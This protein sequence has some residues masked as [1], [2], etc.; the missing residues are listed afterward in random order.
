MSG[1]CNEPRKSVPWTVLWSASRM[2]HASGL[3]ARFHYE[4]GIDH[5]LFLL[6]IFPCLKSKR[7]LSEAKE[8]KKNEEYSSPHW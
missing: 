3:K 1:V 7:A 8:I 2:L 4:R 5:S 6:L